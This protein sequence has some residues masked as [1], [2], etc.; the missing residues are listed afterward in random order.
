[1]RYKMKKENKKKIMKTLIGILGLILISNLVSAA[2]IG[3]SP[4]KIN[5]EN[6]LRGGYAEKYAI[7]SVDSTVPVRV[8]I[9]VRGDIA[10]WLSFE[11]MEFDVSNGKPYYMK[12]MVTPP[13]DIPNGNYS[14][15]IR[16]RTFG[17]GNIAEGQAT[18]IVNAAL[19]LNTN[20]EITDIEMLSCQ[21]TQFM[22]ESVEKGDPII[23]SSEVSNQG[24]IR[25]R[26]VF[27]VE[28]WDENQ[29]E[30][31][32]E[33]EFTGEA[34]PP[35]TSKKITWNVASNDLDLGQYWAEVYSIDCYNSQT[36]TFDVLEEGALKASGVLTSIITPPW[37]EKDDTTTIK[38]YFENN[39]E[40]TVSAMFKGEITLNG[41]IVQILQSEPASVSIGDTN[42]F[43]FYF[44]PREVG[45]YIVT[46][47]VFYDGKRTFEKSA[48][49]NV[50]DTGF[51][52]SKLKMPTIYLILLTAI[53][54][55]FYKIQKERKRYEKNLRRV[56]K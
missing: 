14:G 27:R 49:I 8:N 26:P 4:A 46:G 18:G 34:I 28:I 25:L 29:I 1:M 20:V 21:A 52:W 15:F 51:K 41:K 47:R 45:K 17:E 48:I 19:D 38:A 39:G 24:N 12:I 32:K 23:F 6:V 2:N 11:E 3:I 22:V 16:V 53:A 5:F 54:F 36:L 13:E 31:I 30:I 9:S 7:I 50:R 40:K 33:E 10:D 55:L 44:T 37:V 42:E 43:N 35:T 56:K